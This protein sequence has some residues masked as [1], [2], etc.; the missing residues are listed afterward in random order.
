MRA[1]KQ[2]NK[3]FVVERR[4]VHCKSSRWLAQNQY[5]LSLPNNSVYYETGYAT[6]QMA[7]R[8]VLLKTDVYRLD[9]LLNLAYPTRQSLKPTIDYTGK[10]VG[11]TLYGERQADF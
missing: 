10:R 11:P 7:Q 1:R 5:D 3:R 6:K 2:F 9:Y 8:R 4:I